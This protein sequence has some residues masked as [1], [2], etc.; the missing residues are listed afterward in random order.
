MGWLDNSTN[1][2][3]LD[4][5]LTDY[6]RSALSRNDGSFKIF[7]F[8]LGDDEID[9]ETITKYGRTVGKEKIEKNTPI[10]EAFTNQNLAIKYKLVGIATPVLYLP[11]LKVTITGGGDVAYLV[12]QTG[13]NYSYTNSVNIIV[14]QSAQG[15]ETSLSTDL[16]ESAYDIY[17]PSLFLNLNNN[18][19]QK[20]RP[21]NSGIQLY[22]VSTSASNGA[23]TRL[24]FSL[25]PAA[26]LTSTIFDVY[27][28]NTSVSN[29]KGDLITAR[30]INTSIK[31]VGQSSGA[32]VNVP[33]TIIKA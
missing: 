19:G 16:A 17:V 18:Q 7:K 21:D 28:R 3:I 24:S 10:F 11:K 15:T 22:R 6:G 4:A 20:N 32:S 23:S 5:V 13:S 8:A 29:N 1:N 12:T 25:T 30:A 33:V 14:D 2:I 9:Y 31:I 26:G 27:G